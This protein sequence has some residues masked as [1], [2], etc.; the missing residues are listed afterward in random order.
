V[1]AP[2][3]ALPKLVTLSDTGGGRQAAIVMRRGQGRVVAYA[4]RMDAGGLATAV[5]LSF[6]F[7]ANDDD[8]YDYSQPGTVLENLVFAQTA[9]LALTASATDV[10]KRDTIDSPLGFS[11][12]FGVVADVTA[13]GSYELELTIWVEELRGA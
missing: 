5:V 10:S 13:T 12:G 11:G 1:T 6:Q 2:T 3:I 9:S 8:L 4:V 7:G